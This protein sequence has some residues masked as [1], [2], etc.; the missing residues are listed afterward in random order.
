MLQRNYPFQRCPSP[1][2]GYR[3]TQKSACCRYMLR[4]SLLTGP[5]PDEE[6]TEAYLR[7]EFDW[8]APGAPLTLITAIWHRA[9]RTRGDIKSTIRAHCILAIWGSKRRALTIKGILQALMR[10]ANHFGGDGV[11]RP[12]ETG[13]KQVGWGVSIST[14]ILTRFYTEISHTFRPLYCLFS[15]R[16][17]SLYKRQRRKI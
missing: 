13:S 10:V 7:K 11:Y 12:S 15:L 16:T 9:L 1:A 8:V 14:L 6:A 3:D 17:L 2:W 5:L 4:R